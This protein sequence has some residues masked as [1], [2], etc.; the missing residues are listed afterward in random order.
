MFNAANAHAVRD[1]FKDSNAE[2]F[3]L[4]EE[5]IDSNSGSSWTRKLDQDQ[6]VFDNDCGTNCSDIGFR[7]AAE[8]DFMRGRSM[9]CND[10]S[11]HDKHAR[12]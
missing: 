6:D 3:R 2:I 9:N 1:K 10:A 4:E 12:P 5:A 11:D 8:I 7:A